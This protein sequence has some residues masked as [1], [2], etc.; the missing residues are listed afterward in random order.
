MRTIEIK[1]VTFSELYGHPEWSALEREYIEETANKDVPSP[2]AQAARYFELE[3]RGAL[4]C[5]AV[6]D[7]GRL[8]GLAVLAVLSSQHYPFP[9]VSTDAVFIRRKWRKGALGLRLLRAMGKTAAELGSPGLTFQAPPGSTLD[10]LCSAMGMTHT[11]NLYWCAH[12]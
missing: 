6:L 1:K 11:H 8:A 4:V 5:L 9:I 2:G 10:R 7:G 3:A 12:D